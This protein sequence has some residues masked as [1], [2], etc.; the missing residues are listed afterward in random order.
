VWHD[1]EVANL[2]GL[3]RA[4][5]R[6]DPAGAALGAVNADGTGEGGRRTWG[7]LDA[8]VDA[9]AAGLRGLGLRRG[10]RVGLVVGNSPM[11]V[12]GYL[13]ALRAG[14][15]AVPVDPAYPSAE[16]A[17]VLGD[18]SVSAV[19]VGHAH[20]HVVD[21]AVAGTSRAVVA[22]GASYDAL[23]ASGRDAIAHG[24]L[25]EPPTGGEDPAVLLFTSGTSGRPR[26]AVLSHRAL[27]AN[28]DQCAALEPAP[29]LPGDVVLVVLPLFHVYA[30]NGALGLA[31]RQRAACVLVDGFDP[32]GSLRVIAAERVTSVPA[33]PAMY[34][35]WLAQ[36]QAGP[37]LRGVRLMTSGASALP[38]AVLERVHALTGAWVREG[39]GLTETAPVCTTTLRSARVKPGSVGRP[40]DRLE[41]R[42]VGADGAEVAEEDPG[43]IHVRGPN[44]FSGYWPDRAEDPGADGW[45][46]T[47]DIAYADADG[48]LFLVDRRKELVVVNGFNVYPR[49][50]EDVLTAH[51]DV[52]EAAVVAVPD[53]VSGEAVKAYV[54]ARAGARLDTEN[55][56]RHCA[57][58]LARFK[59]PTL[60]EVVPA[61]PH[62]ATGKVVKHR[63]RATAGSRGEDG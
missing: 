33:A 40:V 24:V 32:A 26:G 29:V 22:E 52:A 9:A 8:D 31:L 54:V 20:E 42:L 60:V 3:L 25:A 15:V 38:A 63:L 1:A 36:E 37:A 48:D 61:L 35:A 4:A 41:L 21:E 19:L 46:A 2:A 30:L 27:L 5:A 13:G 58:R 16:I 6:A 14:L 17:Q 10:D 28:L 51:P 43:E 62:T 57:P 12:T 45:F 23:L 55:L 56:L 39:Y 53:P 50:V 49:E 18:A 7:G 47:G 59:W 34:T 11:F 44:L